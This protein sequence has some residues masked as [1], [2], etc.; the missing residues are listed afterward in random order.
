MQLSMEWSLSHTCVDEK[1][2]CSMTRFG[3]SSAFCSVK[4]PVVALTV[5]PGAIR[6]AGVTIRSGGG[7]VGVVG[8]VVGVVGTVVGVV[9]TVVGVVGTV[10]GV[11]G[12]VVGV[13]GT[14]VGVVGSVVGG[15]PPEP[16]EV[17]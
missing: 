2:H 13:V 6:D 15:P 3:P 5:L 16:F 14:V 4:L 12:T 9:G 11:V 1:P 7:V 17:E 10:V 8:T